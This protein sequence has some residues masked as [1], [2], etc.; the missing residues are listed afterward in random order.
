MNEK[1]NTWRA[2]QDLPP[3]VTSFW[4]RFH[5]HNWTKWSD[6][7]SSNSTIWAQQHRYCIHCN[8]VDEKR[9]ETR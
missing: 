6:V 1:T 5:W 7:Q 2:L 4:C 3:V 8:S 9:W